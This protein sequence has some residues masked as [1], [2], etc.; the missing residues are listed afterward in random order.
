MITPID[1][2]NVWIEV[3]SSMIFLAIGIMLT[4]AVYLV[5][6]YLITKNPG[7]ANAKRFLMISLVIWSILIWMTLNIKLA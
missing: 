3:H 1:V 7:W 2:N 6:S 5:R 4:Q